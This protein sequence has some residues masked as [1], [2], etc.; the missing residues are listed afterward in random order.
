MTARTTD[1]KIES[2]IQYAN[3][4]LVG[5]LL[6]AIA[7]ITALITSTMILGN[8]AFISSV[9]SVLTFLFLYDKLHKLADQWEQ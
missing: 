5:I 6:S 4:A 7:L 2:T 9:F 1:Q 8:I 3:F